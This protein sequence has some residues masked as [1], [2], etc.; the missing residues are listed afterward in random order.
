MS[1]RQDEILR[2]TVGCSTMHLLVR[3][4][5]TR[6]LIGVQHSTPHRP[7][8]A[9]QAVQQELLQVGHRL[10]CAA[11]GAGCGAVSGQ[12]GPCAGQD[13]SHSIVLS[14][15]DI[16]GLNAGQHTG[17]SGRH[18]QGIHASWAVAEVL[19]MRM[20][21]TMSGLFCCTYTESTGGHFGRE[22]QR[23]LREDG[24]NCAQNEGGSLRMVASHQ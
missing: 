18:L 13:V 21:L 19:G 17:G 3:L 2:V 22:L 4:S 9:H 7:A 6:C 11:Q 1:W 23:L 24:L 10:K 5:L 15:A 16:V 20:Q 8:Q 12:L 14:G